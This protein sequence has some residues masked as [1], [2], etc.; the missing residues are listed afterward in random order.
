VRS[1]LGA[2]MVSLVTSHVAL[3]VNR[4]AERADIGAIEPPSLARES[5][6]THVY[7]VAH[8]PASGEDGDADTVDG[9]PLVRSQR[10]GRLQCTGRGRLAGLAM[11]A[12]GGALLLTG[13]L[14][15][16]FKFEFRGLV[17]LVLGDKAVSTYSVVRAPPGLRRTRRNAAAR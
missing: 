3:H 6:S 16:S 1:F 2:A 10:Q 15:P 9:Q 5:L 17:G 11:V 12:A 13:V 14:L 7:L 4:L 8:T